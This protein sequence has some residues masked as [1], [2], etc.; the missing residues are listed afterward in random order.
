MRTFNLLLFAL[1]IVVNHHNCFAA[2]EWNI[3]GLEDEDLLDDE[4]EYDFRVIGDE[5]NQA[6]IAQ[7]AQQDEKYEELYKGITLFFESG[8]GRG[9]GFIASA[10]HWATR[11]W[12][13]NSWGHG[14][15][16]NATHFL[17]RVQ[18]LDLL[19][20]DQGTVLLVEGLG[21]FQRADNMDLSRLI[22]SYIELINKAGASGQ[23]QRLL[24]PTRLSME[25]G[26]AG[27]FVLLDIKLGLDVVEKRSLL[28]TSQD[29]IVEPKI[30]IW[31]S[32][33]YDSWKSEKDILK[34]RIKSLIDDYISGRQ[35]HGAPAKS[36]SFS[37]R[38][39]TQ[40]P[41]GTDCGRYVA[42]SV[43]GILRGYEPDSVSVSDY[44]RL[45]NLFDG[46]G[47]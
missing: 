21:G 31:D 43:L 38:T 2:D 44:T 25:S 13:Q 46:A 12:R 34:A 18:S 1:F 22:D 45:L 6:A 41:L 15:G 8:L 35:I 26:A 24:V 5:D 47:L 33:V 37:E 3:V 10:S 20:V 27:H 11:L 9:S 16:F 28:G 40:Q 42:I 36:V 19:N 7:Q 23:P 29:Y 17:E 39:Y 4:E 14:T 30:T 32:L